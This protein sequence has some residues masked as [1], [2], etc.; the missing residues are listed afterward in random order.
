MFEIDLYEDKD[1][2]SDLSNFFNKLSNSNQKNDQAILKKLLHQLDMLQDL[3]P[4]LNEP[5]AKFLKGY[6]FPIMELRPQPERIFYAA[7]KEN[8]FILLHHYTKRKNKTDPKEIK[9]A[10]NRLQDWLDRHPS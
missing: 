9:I 6:R 5:Q 3:G 8:R 7:W 10:I 1:G 2:K 4:Q